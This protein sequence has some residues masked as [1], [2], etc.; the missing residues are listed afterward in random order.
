MLQHSDAATGTRVQTGTDTDLHHPPQQ[1]AMRFKINL[2][3][4]R[5]M[6]LKWIFPEACICV[7]ETFHLKFILILSNL[8]NIIIVKVLPLTF[9]SILIIY[10]EILT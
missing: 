4:R 5:G 3:F 1:R 6:S 7:D 8:D 10:H 9:R 2:K